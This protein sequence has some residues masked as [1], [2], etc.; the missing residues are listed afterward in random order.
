MQTT[1]KNIFTAWCFRGHLGTKND[2]F[3]MDHRVEM[4]EQAKF[5]E[6]H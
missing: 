2:G 1:V 3:Y 6:K 5:D 4:Q